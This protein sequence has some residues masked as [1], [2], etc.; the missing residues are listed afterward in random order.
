M[1]L[2]SRSDISGVLW[3]CMLEWRFKSANRAST[4][5]QHHCLEPIMVLMDF[6]RFS[7]QSAPFALAGSGA[8]PFYPMCVSIVL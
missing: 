4:M 6:G 2:G 3:V 8:V 5:H 7:A 1:S